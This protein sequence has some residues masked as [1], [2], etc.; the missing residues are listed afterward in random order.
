MFLAELERSRVKEVFACRL[1]K[2]VIRA[3]EM[4]GISHF[5][6]VQIYTP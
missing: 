3:G 6:Y 1:I 2:C 4:G 5:V